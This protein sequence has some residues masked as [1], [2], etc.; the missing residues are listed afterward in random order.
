ME[1]ENNR[2]VVESIRPVINEMWSARDNGGHS[3]VWWSQVVV[4]VWE[5]NEGSIWEHDEFEVLLENS[6]GHMI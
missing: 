4:Q 1:P 5:G 3:A 2:K 6:D